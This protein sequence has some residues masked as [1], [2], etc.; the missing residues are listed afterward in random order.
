M[1]IVVQLH[2]LFTTPR[3]EPKSHNLRKTWIKLAARLRESQIL[4]MALWILNRPSDRANLAELRV[5]EMLAI[6]PDEWVIRWGFYYEDNVGTTREGDFLIL[7]P[8][9]G[10]MLLEV[11]AGSLDFFPAILRRGAITMPHAEAVQDL[12][13]IR[14]RPESALRITELSTRRG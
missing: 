2:T 14:F 8:Q 5:A 13:S 7:G 10:L 11:K 6:L 3:T 4:P 9:G 1:L 12:Q